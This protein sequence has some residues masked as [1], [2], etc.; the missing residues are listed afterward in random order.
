MVEPLYS[1]LKEGRKVKWEPVH[2]EVMKRLKGMLVV[3][4]DL[5]KAIYKEGMPIYVTKDTSPMGIGWV[6][7]QEQKD[8]A[9]YAIQ[10]EE[11]VLSK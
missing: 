4:P 1:L 3:V 7:N 6:I 2:T 9:W 11:K 8:S 5:R 10:L